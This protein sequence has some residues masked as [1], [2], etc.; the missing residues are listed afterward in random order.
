MKDKAKTD[1]STNL[2]YTG[3]GGEPKHLKIETRLIDEI[4]EC[5]MGKCVISKIQVSHLCSN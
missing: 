3:S 5:V 2:G 4:V 1:G